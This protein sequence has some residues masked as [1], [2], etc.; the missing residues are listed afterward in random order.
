MQ[1]YTPQFLFT[2]A[3]RTAPTRQ[4]LYSLADWSKAP[5][6]VDLGC[7][8]GV[9]TPELTSTDPHAHAIGIDFDSELTSQAQANNRT[10]PTLH[11]ILSDATALPLRAAVV[12][13]VL[14]HFTLMWI[15]DYKSALAEIS[16][17][18]RTRAM[19]A[20]IEPDYAGRIEWSPDTKQNHCYPIIKWLR[21]KHANPFIGS[22]L[23]QLLHSEGF[24][25]ITFGVLAWE[26]HAAAAKAEIQDEAA[27]LRAEG[28]QWKPPLV[29][30]TPIFWTKALKS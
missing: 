29:S 18:L 26:Y 11:L 1:P 23:S 6:S 10:N 19:F 27:L 16:R 13:F 5:V 2:Q 30:Y 14:S 17:V 28:I 3:H 22:Q 12:S 15:K 7:G 9:I 4:Y 8:T 25:D 20:A 21:M 24:T